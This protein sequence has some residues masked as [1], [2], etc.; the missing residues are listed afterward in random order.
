MSPPIPAFVPA[1]LRAGDTATWRR[2]L[3]DHSSVDGWAVEYVLVRD[4]EQIVI[5]SSADGAGHLVDVAP[6]ATAAWQPGVYAYVERASLA[7]QVFT[8][9]AGRVEILPNFA[10]AGNGLDARSHAEKT[11]A[12]IEAFLERGDLLAGDYTIGDKS[13]RRIPIPD[14]LRLR[15][16]YRREARQPVGRSGRV[17][18]RF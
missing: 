12:A 7:G 5:P 4:G 18:V 16:V 15:D 10:D 1:S 14:L 11:L 2:T 3:A 17:Y 6:A 13:I 9:A 8:T